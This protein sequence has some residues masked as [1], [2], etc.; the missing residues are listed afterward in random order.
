MFRSIIIVVYRSLYVVLGTW[1]MHWISSLVVIMDT[2]AC[3]PPTSDHNVHWGHISNNRREKSNIEIILMAWLDYATPTNGKV[4][5]GVGGYSVYRYVSILLPRA[6]HF[7]LSFKGSFGSWCYN[8][9]GMESIPRSSSPSPSYVK[10]LM[11][12]VFY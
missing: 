11:P 9:C 5:Y 12:K 6:M 3:H 2:I 10:T 7:F 8:R 4:Y 1:R